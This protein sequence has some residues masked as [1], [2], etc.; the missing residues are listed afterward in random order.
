MIHR[1]L[2]FLLVLV[3]G[4]VL[5]G[6]AAVPKPA[7]GWT[8]ELV[9]QAPDVS[10]PSVVATAPDGR[11]FVAEDPMDI[12]EDVK[13]DA[14]AGR[15]WCLHPDG[16]RTLFAKDLHAVFGMQHLEGKLYVLHNP[17][18]T[19]FRDD[20]GVG[21]EPVDL[22]THTL[23]EPWGLGWNDH[24]PAN[25]KLGMDGYF[26]LAVGD[27]GLEDCTGTDGRKISMPGGGVVRFRPDG[28]GLEIFATGVRN[29]L[30]VALD[31]DDQPFTYDNTDEHQWMG[32]L[33]HMVEAGFYG[34]PHD[35]IP[36]RPYTLWMMHDFGAGAACGT[37]CATDDGLPAAMSGNLFLSDFGKRQ[38][39]RVTVA[40]DGAGF[41]VAGSE[42]LF[43]E[44][45]DDFRPVGI[46]WSVDGRSMFIC[47]WQHRDQ[48]ANVSVGRLWKLT[49]T[50]GP[51][52]KA[53][54][55]WWQ[56][57]AMGRP[58]TM[59]VA[60]PELVAALAHPARSVRLTAQRTLAARA[61][62][63][64]GAPIAGQLEE[65]L[66]DPAAS[67]RARKHA[68]WALDGIDE[69]VR[70]RSTVTALAAGADH[71]LAAQAL[72]QLSQRRVAAAVPVAVRALTAA[73]AP[74]RLQAATLLGRVAD[75]AAVAPLMAS[76]GTETDGVVRFAVFTALRRTVEAHDETAGTVVAGLGSSSPQ[77]REGCA[78]ALRD[79]FSTAVVAQLA[80]TVSGP[81]PTAAKA[82]MEVLAPLARRAPAVRDSWWAYHPAD[83]PP[84]ARTL[85]WA[86][87]PA[88]VATLRTAL[89][90]PDAVVRGSATAALGD[91]GDTV[92]SGPLRRRL[93]E[94]PAAAVRLSALASLAKIDPAGASDSAA[95]FLVA[96]A[97][98]ELRQAALKQ[99]AVRPRPGTG[100][101][102][103]K[104]LADGAA[105]E[106]PLVLRAMARAAD[107][108]DTSALIASAKD[109]ALRDLAIRALAA[110]PDLAAVPLLL[111]GVASP[112]PAVAQDSRK[113]LAKLG[114]AALPELVK[115]AG[116]I[117]AGVRGTLRDVFKDVP[118][119]KGSPL[120]ASLP[121]ADPAA[122][123]EFA[124]SHPGDPWRGQQ[125]F[126]GA[127]GV[128]CNACHQVAGHGGSVGP[129]LT[130]AGRQ[131]GRPE[132][133]ESI[134]YPGRIVREGYRQT[135]IVTTDDRELTGIVKNR[136]AKEIALT[137]VSGT[138]TVIPLDQVK[139]RR[140]LP[141]S[142]M[143]DELHA[144]L[145]MEQF[146][147]LVAFVASRTSD[148]RTQAKPP[149]PAGFTSLFNGHDLA[150]WRTTDQ[151][152]A[153]WSVKDGRILHDGVEGDLWHDR[154]LV[155]FELLVEWRWPGLPKV[156]DFPVID[157]D[158]R[159]LTRTERV[160]DAGDSGVF[161]R[162]LYKA[163]A[164][165][166][167][168]PVGSGEFWEYRSGMEGEARRAV[169]PSARADAPI[170]DWN[171]MRVTVQGD[172]VSVVLN[173]QKVISSA[174]LPGLP[175]KGPMGLQHEHGR[176]EVRT[177]AVR[178]LP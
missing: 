113:A 21:R 46:G 66:K 78:G 130:S 164:N 89:D 156:V 100:P 152:R 159:E 163:Q 158:G 153:H 103:R 16:R 56:G 157:A 27:K 70:G 106:K 98:P 60:T 165:L 52:P 40:R 174:R 118:E 7:P 150:G 49:W 107:A 26:Y 134:L 75:T 166:F 155:D 101:I 126:F 175:A 167:C 140:E 99:L 47:D 149:V 112:D 171:S 59:E 8:M 25:F 80:R 61:R 6:R 86:G 137:D 92:S 62:R 162:G 95:A 119:A 1:L 129:D 91:V 29:I 81:D 17:F 11:V 168:Y 124:K 82:A 172:Q 105:P 97:M 69:G 131:F 31:E 151:N 146:A 169:T 114:A 108:S 125:I 176:L 109:P 67:D 13:P 55:K 2:P 127:A 110:A 160:L 87:T 84:P 53:W 111:E 74:V 102:L 73:A 147:D 88:V 57:L 44:P 116:E 19:V 94:D 123:A 48:K 136:S 23:R 145:T 28:S 34:Y 121:A 39:T 35:F 154:D 142:M 148:P 128:A 32:R 38:V 104:L 14:K 76:L 50:G 85:D 63:P 58:D 96:D 83:S 68:L 42:E 10:H 33:T 173:G 143:P 77:V 72:R 5:S 36:R 22:F 64:D 51:E 93:A 161:V 117:P 71:P 45:P 90:H 43:P 41:R 170:G 133:I 15:I 9:A 135:E 141:S 12:R 24:V 18:L 79:L 139:E 115:R 178:V 20:D 4:P 144:G 132:I 37:L 120:F 3:V 138:V 177:V 122:Y 30:D 54:P 65:L